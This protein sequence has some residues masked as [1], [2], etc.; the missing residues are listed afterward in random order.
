MIVLAYR[1]RRAALLLALVLAL[2]LPLPACGKKGA[3]APP[4]RAT[5]WLAAP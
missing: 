1:R 5:A 3:P 2:L 4:A